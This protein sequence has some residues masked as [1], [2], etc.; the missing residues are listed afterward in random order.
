MAEFVPENWVILRLGERKTLHFYD[1]ALVTKTITD[2]VTGRTKSVQSLTMYVDLENDKKVD[3]MFS[4]ISIKLAQAISAY[5]PDRRYRDYLFVIEKPIEK[6]AP[7]Y[8]VEV[9]PYKRG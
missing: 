4:V 7:P 3:K 6:F 2:P 9:I 5:I 8:L 1:H